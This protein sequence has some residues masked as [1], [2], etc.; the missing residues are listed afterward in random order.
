[1]YM[2]TSTI[3]ACTVPVPVHVANCNSALVQCLDLT[4]CTHTDFNLTRSLQ[5]VHYL[6]EPVYMNWNGI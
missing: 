6:Y 1:M 4:Q 2:Y 5:F 3:P